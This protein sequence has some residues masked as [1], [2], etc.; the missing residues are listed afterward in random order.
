MI[1]K[2]YYQ[3]N[4]KNAYKFNTIGMHSILAYYRLKYLSKIIQIS[5]ITL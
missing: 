4:L 2:F 1:N 3:H 5:G